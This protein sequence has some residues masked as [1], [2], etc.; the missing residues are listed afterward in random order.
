MR[1]LSVAQLKAYLRYNKRSGAFTWRISPAR[2]I[3][4]GDS[5]GSMHPQGYL[6]IQLCGK[7]YAAHRLAWLYVHGVWPVGHI[8][9]TDGVR[10]NNK[11]SNLR[12]VTHTQNLQ[13]YR[14][15]RR[16]SRAGLLGVTYRTDSGM[17]Q[18]RIQR[19]KKSVSLGTF[20]TAEAAHTAYICAKNKFQKGG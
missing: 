2:C 12:D 16:G 11:I 19:D 14:K 1:S 10:S 7:L 5:A 4:A 8:D 20:Q 9:H 13:A 15:A 17:W 18:A 6:F 3:K